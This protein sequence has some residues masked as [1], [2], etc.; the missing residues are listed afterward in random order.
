MKLFRIALMAL[1][2][3]GVAACSKGG[4]ENKA[5]GAQEKAKAA[6]QQQQAPAAAPA[7]GGYDPNKDA[8]SDC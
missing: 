2:V 4:D 7:Q 6:V 3:A 1:F 8:D 5:Q